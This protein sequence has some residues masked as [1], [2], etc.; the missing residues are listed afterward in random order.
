M[1]T[2]EPESI[3]F[4]APIKSGERIVCVFVQPPSQYELK[5]MLKALNN[6]RS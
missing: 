5:L 3:F 6:G 2:Y 1:Y 4:R